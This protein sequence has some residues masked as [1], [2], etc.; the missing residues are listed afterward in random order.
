MLLIGRQQMIQRYQSSNNGTTGYVRRKRETTE[1][2]DNVFERNA[3]GGGDANRTEDDD[4]TNSSSAE[5]EDDDEF[6]LYSNLR[7]TLEADGAHQDDSEAADAASDWLY[8]YLM[9][10]SRLERPAPG[11]VGKGQQERS[12]KQQCLCPPG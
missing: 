1:S 5:E 6:M 11:S 3:A 9:D 8:D 12:K 4:N 2:Y 7:S 10:N